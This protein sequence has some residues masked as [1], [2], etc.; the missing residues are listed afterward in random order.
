MRC[1]NLIYTEGA[2]FIMMT[3][4]LGNNTVKEKKSQVTLGIQGVQQET[5]FVLT[6]SW[7]KTKQ[8]YSK[9]ECLCHASKCT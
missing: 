7:A 1:I 8:G 3:R 6:N 5:A 9:I 4:Q 2:N